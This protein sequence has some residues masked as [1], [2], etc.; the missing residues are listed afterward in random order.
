MP[1]EP[2]TELPILIVLLEECGDIGGETDA[3][4]LELFSDEDE[5][6]MEELVAAAAYRVDRDACEDDI[7]FCCRAVVKSLNVKSAV[8]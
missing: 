1:G 3:I 6:L 4:R 8:P 2:P 5:L 7:P